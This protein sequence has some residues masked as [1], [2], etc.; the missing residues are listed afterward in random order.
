[1]MAYVSEYGYANGGNGEYTSTSD[2]CV[3]PAFM[4]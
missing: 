1:M 4:L 2:L 3:R